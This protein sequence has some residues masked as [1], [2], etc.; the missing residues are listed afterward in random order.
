MPALFDKLGIHFQYP[1]NWTVEMDSAGAGRQTVSVYSPEGAF[2]TVMR[3]S[4][5][6]DPVELAQTALLA[7]QNEYDELDS[8]TARE[9]IGEVELVGFDLNFYCLDLTNTAWIRVGIT[10]TATYLLICQA[11]DREFER[12]SVVFRAMMTSLLSEASGK[13]RAGQ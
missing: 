11:E 1:E 4:A 7:M 13:R 10:K 3:H 6:T 9:Q 12:I 8:E 5:D 2:W